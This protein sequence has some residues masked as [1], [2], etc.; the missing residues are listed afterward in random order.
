MWPSPQH[1]KDGWRQLPSSQA[2]ALSHARWGTG[3]GE[4]RDPHRAWGVKGE[5]GRVGR[6]HLSGRRRSCPGRRAGHQSSEWWRNIPRHGRCSCLA[7]QRKGRQASAARHG[8]RRAGLGHFCDS[9]APATSQ[10]GCCCA[11]VRPPAI[12]V[13]L[14]N[15]TVSSCPGPTKGPLSSD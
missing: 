9:P 8:G 6:A 4:G 7:G 1:S 3:E 11:P 5:A 13:V 10:V 15:Y 14:L 12:K 2:R